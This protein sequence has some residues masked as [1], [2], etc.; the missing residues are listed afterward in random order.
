MLNYE[1]KSSWPAKNIA[2][3]PI[4]KPIDSKDIYKLKENRWFLADNP[5]LNRK[6]NSVSIVPY[7]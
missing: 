7:F 5:P 1:L 4:T 2:F 6:I 3:G